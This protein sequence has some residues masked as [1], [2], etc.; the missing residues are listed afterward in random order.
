MKYT[1]TIVLF[2]ITAST[3]WGENPKDELKG[4]KQEIRAK[5]KLISKTRKV[6]AVV[7][8]E[9]LEIN[10]NLV[11]KETDLGKLDRDLR[12]VETSLDR[13]GREI[14]RVTDE[15]NRKKKEIERDRKSVV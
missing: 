7:S 2:M 11:Q 1:F 15:A 10:R 3:V 5:K 8:T 6:E 13:T 9:L 12:G 14:E 4:V